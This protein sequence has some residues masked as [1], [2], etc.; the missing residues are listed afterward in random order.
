MAALMFKPWEKW[1]TN[2]KLRPKLILLIVVS[3]LLLIGKQL[4]NVELFYQSVIVNQQ[5]K[6]Q[7]LAQ[8]NAQTLTALMAIENQD[9]T[10]AEQA[11][12]ATVANNGV[13][14]IDYSNDKKACSV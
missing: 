4:W 14:V 9:F 6:V 10:L 1:L 8:S 11:L 5:D 13:Y 12:A 3:L 7:Q 2:L